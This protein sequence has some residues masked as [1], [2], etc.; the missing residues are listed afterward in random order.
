MLEFIHIG[1]S[2]KSRGLD[3]QFKIRIDASL[4]EVVTKAR[5]L[6]IDLDGSK[7]PFLIEDCKDQGDVLVKLEEVDNP[8]EASKLLNR[9]L[10]LDKSEVP[11]AY[12]KQLEENIHPFTGFTIIDTEDVQIGSIIEIVEY[13]EQLMAKVNYKGKQVLIP[14]HPDFIVDI[15]E[16]QR[17]LKMNLPDGLLNL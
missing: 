13:P 8:E 15:A 16:E 7:V 14:I 12:F 4:T 17:H 10:F 6:F 2:G 1:Q 3:G 5:A 11:E 9:P